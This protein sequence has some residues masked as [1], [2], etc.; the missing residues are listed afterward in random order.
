ML[1]I[2]FTAADFARV[3]FAPRPAPLQELNSALMKLCLP[4]S[5]GADE[6]L[7]GRWRRR[8][9]AALPAAAGALG[10]LVPAGVAPVFLDILSDDLTDGLDAARA[11]PAELVRTETERV[12]ARHPA[13]PPPWIRDLRR[14]DPRAWRLLHRAQRAAF[15]TALAP[16]WS[17]VQDL[18]QEEFTRHAVVTAAH[19][20]G[21]A[22]TA[23]VPGSRLDGDI[24]ELPSPTARDLPLDGRGLLLLPTFHWTG[25]PLIATPPD[26]A[27]VAL[28][29]AAGPGLPLTPDTT[30][31]GVEPLAGVIGRTRAEMLLVLADEH[32]TSALAR[33]LRV[34][35]ATA[36]AH[37]GALRAAGLI[38]TTRAGRA[39]LHRR[40]A[41][42]TLLVRGRGASGVA[43]DAG[44]PLPS[45]R[46]KGLDY[47]R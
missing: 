37:A 2:H 7:F 21:H 39:V 14:G 24:W 12:Y 16:T 20:V 4:A 31:T 19:G 5:G 25:H 44:R 36:S 28:T 11:T 13:P 10:E 1:R 23:L 3:R 40:T 22:L 43:S 8:L 33:R 6:L 32:T 35:N 27:T 15:E 9:F 34:G 29:Y 46:S 18:H 42:G 45:A 41:M 30:G 47:R 38:A 17:R 26:G